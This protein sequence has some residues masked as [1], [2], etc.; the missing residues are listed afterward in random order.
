[1]NFPN[2]ENY[3]A[4]TG[5]AK[6]RL[7][8]LMVEN[9]RMSDHKS[10]CRKLCKTYFKFWVNIR[11]HSQNVALEENVRQKKYTL[12]V[13]IPILSFRS[14]RLIIY[15]NDYV[16]YELNISRNLLKNLV[17]V[18]TSLV[19]FWFNKNCTCISKKV[20]DNIYL[21]DESLKFFR[22]SVFARL[23]KFNLRS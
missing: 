17:I 23:R 16:I 8:I 15:N 4:L 1:M 9:F 13:R 7:P 12:S 20:Y 2:H 22:K 5:F 14:K 6:Y 11:S 10:L 18:F 21:S 19:D 3:R